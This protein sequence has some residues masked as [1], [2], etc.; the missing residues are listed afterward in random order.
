MLD[1][2]KI[3]PR[4]FTVLVILTTIGDSIL[5]LPSAPAQMAKQDAW[6]SALFGL[7]IGLLALSLISSLAKRFPRFTFVEMSRTLL[8]KMLGTVIACLF[9]FYMLMNTAAILTEMGNFLNTYILAETPFE[10]IMLFFLCVTIM[11][12]RLGLEPLTR[13]GEVFFPW[14][15][16]LLIAFIVMLLPQIHPINLQPAFEYGIGPIING[17]I[18][19]I[20]YPFL[21]LVVFLMVFPSVLEPQKLR[22]CF[23]FGALAGGIVLVLIILLCILVL[24]HTLTG[25]GMY[26]SYSMAFRI[27]IGNWLQRI[28]AVMATLWFVSIFFKLTLSFYAICRALAQLFGLQDFRAIAVPVGLILMYPAIMF[29]PNVA[30]MY[31]LTKVWPFFDITAGFLL[32]LLLLT[33][34]LVRKKGGSAA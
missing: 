23:L 22:K 10:I 1:N 14:F 25:Q 20:A 9:V 31:A 28:E 24:G 15:M 21:E 5:V 29:S 7:V 27:I 17:S 16:L 34:A 19:T 12:A 3:M 8:G 33:C 26:P 13:A 4:Q 32:P 2:H 6:L 11:G 18:P 30:K